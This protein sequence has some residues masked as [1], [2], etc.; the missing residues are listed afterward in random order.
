VKRSPFRTATLA[1]LCLA[2]VLA[3]AVGRPAAVTRTA[4]ADGQFWDVQDTS[5]WSQ[6]SGGIATGG[7]A[8]P[9]NGFRYL[10]RQGRRADSAPLVT[11]RSLTRFGLAADGDARFDSMTPVV[12]GDIVVSRAIFAPRDTDYLRYF[13]ALTNAADDDRIVEV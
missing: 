8:M 10:K 1:A 11:T 9:F 13:D 7:R 3:G 2:I 6:D 4:S 12:A 5:P